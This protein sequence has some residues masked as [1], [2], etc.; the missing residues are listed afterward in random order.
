M[1]RSALAAATSVLLGVIG[2]SVAA[3]PAHAAG[4]CGVTV[5]SRIVMDAP[6]KKVPVTY[7]S[8]CVANEAFASW[9]ITHSYYGAEGFLLYDYAAGDDRFDYFE[10]YD[11]QPLGGYT[12]DA[13]SAY[14]QA[15]YSD[16]T[17]NSPATTIKLG[18]RVALQVTRSG[19]RAYFRTTTS[20][21]SPARDAFARYP[22]AKV[23]V[24]YKS[25][26]TCAWATLRL[27]YT[28][29]AAA[30]SFSIAS[31]KKFY[32][33]SVLYSGPKTWDAQ[34]PTLFR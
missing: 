27:G 16:L 29:S 5:S 12:L 26:A 14:S 21:Y 9:Q 30:W 28:D 22:N 33:R 17:Q 3:S 2:L 15:D 23:A 11:W 10:L 8:D 7:G 18:T 13:Q 1:L 31:T 19:G 6:Y 25:C 20:A 32:F 4:S 34:G 24:Q